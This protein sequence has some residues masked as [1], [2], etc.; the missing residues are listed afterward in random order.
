MNK[1][2]WRKALRELTAKDKT[3]AV[4]VEKHGELDFIPQQQRSPFESLVRSIAHQQLSGKAAETI[5]NRF[6]GLYPNMEF[7]KPEDILSTSDA[8][9]RESGFS[10]NKIRAIKD[11]ALKT[12]EGIV[13]SSEEVSVLK[14]QEII[15]RLTACYGVGTWTVQMMLIFQLG[16]PDIWPIDDFGIRKGFKIWKRKREMPK[17]RDLI[18][19]SQKWAPYRT[20]VSLYLWQLA[21]CS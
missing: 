19:P 15:E 11:I 2:Q 6:L 3:F 12:Q 5:L 13:P 21:S 20:V 17:P 8:K 14:D 9:I 7:P 10:F 18:K 1:R 4:L 16:R